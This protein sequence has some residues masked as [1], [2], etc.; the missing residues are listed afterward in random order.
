MGSVEE[1]RAVAS[2][3][4]RRGE[5]AASFGLRWPRTKQTHRGK[6]SRVEK[7][8]G[9]LYT[10]IDQDFED[11]LE[12]ETITKTPPAWWRLGLGVHRPELGVDRPVLKFMFSDSPVKTDS[13]VEKVSGSEASQVDSAA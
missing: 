9:L 10:L 2:R 7:L 13:P 5:R 8:F 6:Q 4:R 3:R 1:V 12:A 11:W